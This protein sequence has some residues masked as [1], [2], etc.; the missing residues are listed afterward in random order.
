MRI[1]FPEVTQEIIAFLSIVINRAIDTLDIVG[2]YVQYWTQVLFN[3]YFIFGRGIWHYHITSYLT[4]LSVFWWLFPNEDTLLCLLWGIW[5]SLAFNPG[6]I[7]VP[8]LNDLSGAAIVQ[9]T[10]VPTDNR[11]TSLDNHLTRATL[12]PKDHAVIISCLGWSY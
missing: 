9:S 3:Q 1:A 2:T 7:W 10:I 5:I 4:E 8:L 12:P 11:K 6:H